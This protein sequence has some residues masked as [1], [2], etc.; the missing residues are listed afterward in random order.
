MGMAASIFD[1]GLRARAAAVAL[2]IVFASVLTISTAHAQTLTVLHSFT[3][4]GDGR[5]P[6]A[7]VTR[8]EAGNLYGTAVEGG[9]NDLGAVYKLAHKGSGWELSTLYSFAN[10]DGGNTPFGSVT[11]GSDGNL[12]GA[13][14]EGGQYGKG[15]VYKLSPPPALC[16]SV[17]CPWTETV[18]HQFTG[19]AD[20]AYPEATPIFDSSG[21]L[22][23]TADGGGNANNG[24][25]FELINSGSGW[26]EKVLY[27]FGGSP[28]GSIPFSS[29]T[30]DQTGNLYGTTVEGGGG[31]GTVYQLVPSGSGWTEKVLYAFQGQNDGSTPYAGVTPDPAGNLYGATFYTGVNFGGT[32]F[33][34]TPSDGNWIFSVIYSPEAPLG[35][36]EGTLV[37]SSNGNLYGTIFSGTG[38]GCSGYGCGSLYELTPSNGGWVYTSLVSFNGDD[39]GGN[40][41]GALIFDPA[42]NLYGTTSGSLGGDGSV[43]EVTP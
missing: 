10:G 42:G 37:R 21:N 36:P 35:G 6:I 1:I 25:V 19:F 11:I 33:Q 2:L 28:D 14:A 18:L 31:Y 24:V 16:R 27:I 23:G 17:S 13:A 22:Y 34:L 20:G 7:G 40:P 29:V 43:Y 39:G 12:Y 38:Q 8:D 26:N 9:A 30:F 32:I 3:G 41:E 15:T 5:E 4:G